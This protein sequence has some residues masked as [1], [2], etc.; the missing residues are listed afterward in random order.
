MSTNE[1]P[2]GKFGKE[3]LENYVFPYLDDRTGTGPRFGSDFNTLELDGGKVLVVSTDPLAAS[4]RLG[5]ERSGKLALQVITTDVA[6]SGI[7]PSYLLTNWNLPPGTS[8]E[9]FEKIWRGF[10]KEA[11]RNDVTIIGGHTGR[12]EGSSFPTIGAGTAFG[13]GEK[14]ELVPNDPYPGDRIFLLNRLGLEAAAIFSFYHPDKL[15]DE[16]SSSVATSVR[17]K[18]DQ[19]QPTRDLSFLASL[20]GVRALHD[21]AEGGLLGGLQETLSNKCPGAKISADRITVDQ[22]VRRICRFLDLDPMRVTSIGSGIAVVSSNT[23]EEFDRRSEEKSLPVREVGEITAAEELSIE[24]EEGVEILEDP[25][26][27][28]FWERL[29]EF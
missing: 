1:P 14:E 6:V 9:T 19:I 2:L 11:D 15:S 25:V 3:R 26:H 12:Y 20:P 27:D 22:N 16:I 29:A 4:S 8:D 10:T 5:W 18:F 23:A 28:E 24:T 7:R 13:L 17:R 21:L